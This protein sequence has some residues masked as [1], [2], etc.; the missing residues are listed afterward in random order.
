MTSLHCNK[1]YRLCC[2][3]AMRIWLQIPRCSHWIEVDVAMIFKI[4]ETNGHDNEIVNI[5]V[6]IVIVNLWFFRPS[7]SQTLPTAI[8][9]LQTKFDIKIDVV[10]G[11]NSSVVVIWNR[12][13]W[14]DMIASSTTWGTCLSGLNTRT[15]TKLNI[16]RSINKEV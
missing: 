7:D 6:R 16:I 9:K 15:K 1:N 13:N 4:R 2:D 14:L 12:S 3:D 8:I 11:S 5:Q 10:H